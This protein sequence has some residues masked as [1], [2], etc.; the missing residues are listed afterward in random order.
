[1]FSD[2][3]NKNIDAPRWTDHPFKEEHFKNK[4]CIVPI[5]DIRNL[6]ITFPIPDLHEHFR[7]SVIFIFHTSRILM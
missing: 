5:K 1:M 7:S 2:I 4:W 6:N 3:E